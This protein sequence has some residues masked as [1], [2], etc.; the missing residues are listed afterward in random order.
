MQLSLS[1]LAACCAVA[2]P[3]SIGVRVSTASWVGA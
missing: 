2:L 1:L 3:T